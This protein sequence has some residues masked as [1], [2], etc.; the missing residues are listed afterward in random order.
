MGSTISAS[1]PEPTQM[2]ALTQRNYT[3]EAQAASARVGRLATRL[4]PGGW[5]S[6]RRRRS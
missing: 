3:A 4:T 2:M 5:P 6:G 1:R